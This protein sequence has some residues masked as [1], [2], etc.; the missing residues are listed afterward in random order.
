M[1]MDP[2]GQPQP[3]TSEVRSN[4]QSNLAQLE[5]L[6]QPKLGREAIAFGSHVIILL[7]ASSVMSMRHNVTEPNEANN[8]W[9]LG[10]T[11]DVESS[12]EL[13]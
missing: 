11:E 12:Q 3:V 4:I 8:S 10:L 9:Q 6:T 13:L 1:V 5:S 2:N 7:P